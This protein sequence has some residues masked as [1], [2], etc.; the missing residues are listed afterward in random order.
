M[1]ERVFYAFWIR[2]DVKQMKGGGCMTKKSKEKLLLE[3]RNEILEEVE[4]WKHICF[5]GC[6]DP[7]WPD[8]CNMNL[9]RN[10]IMYYKKKIEELCLETGETLPDEYYIPVPP[11]VDNN[12]MANLEQKERVER[13]KTLHKLKKEKVEYDEQQL[14]FIC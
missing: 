10:H 5:E 6:N 3:Y 7:F 11:E 4:H 13:L 12:Y 2:V 1:Q 8:G 14:S 9:T